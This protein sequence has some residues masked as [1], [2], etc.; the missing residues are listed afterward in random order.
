[1]QDLNLFV[2]F[3]CNVKSNFTLSRAKR[4]RR[5]RAFTVKFTTLWCFLL[6]Y[7]QLLLL[8]PYFLHCNYPEYCLHTGGFR[9][10]PK[11][12]WKRLMPLSSEAATTSRCRS[13]H[14]AYP[15]GSSPKFWVT[16]QNL[17][18]SL[19]KKM[20]TGGLKA[21]CFHNVS[22]LQAKTSRMR[23]R[24]GSKQIHRTNILNWNSE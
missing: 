10:K 2:W 12:I 15:G 7:Q 23:F 20:A 4:W 22:K 19:I 6:V 3:L 14:Y 24:N 17:C 9:W 18:M 16:E 1:M 13:E 11:G 5:R 8:P 21:L